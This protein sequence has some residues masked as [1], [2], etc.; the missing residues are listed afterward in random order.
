MLANMC[1]LWQNTLSCW[2]NTRK[3]IITQ[4]KQKQSDKNVKMAFAEAKHILNFCLNSVS[5]VRQGRRSLKSFE[6]RLRQFHIEV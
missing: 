3:S 5:N 1:F 6:N 2:H 4:E